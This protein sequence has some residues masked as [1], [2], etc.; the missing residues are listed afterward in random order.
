VE[1]DVPRLEQEVDLKPGG[2][3]SVTRRAVNLRH[4][5]GREGSN[6]VP[7]LTCPVSTCPY[8]VRLQPGARPPAQKASN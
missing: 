5:Q 6:A 1:R 2:D 3:R 7:H 4:P 8:T